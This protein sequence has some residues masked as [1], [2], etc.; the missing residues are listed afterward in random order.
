[1]QPLGE[2]DV[3]Q[4]EQQREIECGTGCRCTPRRPRSS[5]R[6]NCA[7]GRARGSSPRRRALA[8]CRCEANGGIV[9]P[10]FDPSSSTASAAPSPDGERRARG[11]P[12]NQPVGGRGLCR[13]HAE[14]AVVVDARSAQG[15]A[16]E[17]A[18]LVRLLVGEASAEHTDRV[19]AVP[20]RGSHPVDPVGD[21]VERLVPSGLVQLAVCA[22]D[23]RGGEP[24]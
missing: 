2:H 1:M 14:P 24:V 9:S 21:Q 3:A 7:A 12:R 17:L 5:W 15:D 16:G 23:Q 4:P 11:R 10:T 6:S 22:A 8:P 13:R 20:C 19:R 18:E